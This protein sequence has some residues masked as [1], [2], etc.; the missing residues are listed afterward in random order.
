MRSGYF[1]GKCRRSWEIN[2]PFAGGRNRSP[3]TRKCIGGHRRAIGFPSN[4][5]TLRKQWVDVPQTYIA[6]AIT[7]CERL[8][9][10]RRKN[11]SV[12]VTA[13]AASYFGLA[14]S[15]KR[16]NLANGG[17][18]L[19]HEEAGLY[20]FDPPRT[21]SA[22]KGGTWGGATN[23]CLSDPKTRITGAQVNGGHSSALHVERVLAD[24]DGETA[25]LVNYVA[26]E[27]E[28]C[29][30]CRAIQ[31]TPHIPIAGTST[32]SARTGK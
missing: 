21:F 11:K 16:P 27:L 7:F 14:F 22:R 9:L 24:C 28:H 23:S 1:G 30:I 26:S 6:R 3:A 8:P 32:A 5:P 4:T 10:V 12:T 19:L 25:G 15:D 17:L 29:E 18:H 20:R 13:H 2:D 31:K